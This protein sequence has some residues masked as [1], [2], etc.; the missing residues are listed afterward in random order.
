[1]RMI[2]TRAK[3]LSSTMV[4]ITSSTPFQA[5]AAS[6]QTPDSHSPQPVATTDHLFSPP[7]TLSGSLST[8]TP[9]VAHRGPIPNTTKLHFYAL[10]CGQPRSPSTKPLPSCRRSPLIAPSAPRFKA[11][12][13]LAS[14]LPSG[15]T[16]PLRAITISYRAGINRTTHSAA[17]ALMRSKTSTPALQSSLFA[18][19]RR[20]LL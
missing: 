17:T 2:P 18:F 3:T 16:S 6:E 8:A 1:M 13:T 15:A 20:V 19:S 10:F 7:S 14:M 12:A 5:V 4:R 11:S 9:G